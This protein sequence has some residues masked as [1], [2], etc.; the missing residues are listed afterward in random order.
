MSRG[1]RWRR[2][3]AGARQI[4]IGVF[5]VGFA[6]GIWM[7][8]AALQENSPHMPDAAKSVPV[9]PPEL[10][11]TPDGVL[12]SAW[13]ARTLALPPRVSLMEL[14]L[15]RLRERLLADGQVTSASLTRQ[16]PDRLI[17]HITE[18]TPVARIRVE[19]GGRAR[20]WL[21]ARDGVVFGG[22]GYETALLDSMPWL[23]GVALVPE[24]AGFRPIPRMDLISRLLTDAQFAAEPLYRSWQI[25]SLARLD[26]DNEIEVTTKD[27]TT[28]VF[29]ARGEFFVQLS[30]L[31]Y[32]MERVARLPRAR[33]RIDLS[34]GREVPV[35]I[36]PL[37]PAEPKPAQ[38]TAV[39]APL[40][41]VFPHSQSKN[42]REL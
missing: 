40:F 1:G 7:I 14:D 22:S 29:A 28:V 37:E 39:A 41:T 15:G 27:N 23:G 4:A 5:V 30:N 10:K 16:F 34:L 26:S 38:T 3:M 17:V 8:G 25:V 21:V 12:D 9:K 36:E 33:A 32:M 20:D 24:G 2:S 35:M 42:Q 19:Q 31:D 13:L 11:T 18:R 6:W